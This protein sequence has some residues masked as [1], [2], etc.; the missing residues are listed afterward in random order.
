MGRSAEAV[1][2]EQELTLLFYET[3]YRVVKTPCRGKYR[4]HNDYSL[5]FGSGRNLF[6][7][8]DQRNYLDG[9]QRELAQISH[10]REHQA[11]NAEKIKTA[12]AAHNAPFCDVSVEIVPY[13]GTKDLSIYAVVILTCQDG[14]KLLYRTGGM[15]DYLTH[16]EGKWYGFE[17]C[18]AHLLQ[19]ACGDRAYCRAYEPD[20]PQGKVVKHHARKREERTR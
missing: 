17:K 10:F 11:E 1:Q 6:V 8:M 16:G 5:V 4:G 3:T 18:M 15:N 14:K 20:T 12:L 7:A 19:D 2:L 13:P 9:L